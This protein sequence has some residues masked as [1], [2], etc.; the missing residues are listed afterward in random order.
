MVICNGD[1]CVYVHT[2]KTNGKMYVGITK[3]GI[4]KR[5]H[6]GY[7]YINCPRFY[8]AIKKY[9]WDGFEHKI[10]ASN[11]TQEEAQN[12]EKLLIKTLDLQN[13]VK[14][15]NIAP[16]GQGGDMNEETKQKI[17]KANKGKRKPESWVK[18]R[19]GLKAGEKHPLYGTKAS[20]ETKAKMSE[21]HKKYYETH[22]WLLK[23]K[24]KPV[25]QIETNK[26][27]DSIELAAQTL[28]ICRSS[29]SECCS[30]KRKSAGG[31]TW[32]FAS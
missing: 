24:R 31:Y 32:M 22:E 20:A 5:W 29:I 30:G 13:P 8:R 28:D 11:L 19:I 7:G 14:G 17:S 15:Y 21:S 23:P 12:M 16:G 18:K 27:F 3:V 6:N 9:G 2:N 26:I 10:F 25:I 4:E 1:Y